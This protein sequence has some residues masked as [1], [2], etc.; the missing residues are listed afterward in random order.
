MITLAL[1][2]SVF[3][4]S[5]IHFLDINTKHSVYYNEGADI[6]V[7]TSLNDTIR[8]FIQDLDGVEAISGIVFGL[9]DSTI[10]MFQ[11]RFV[12]PKT[13]PLAAYFKETLYGI[14]S[15]LTD[16]MNAITDNQSIILYEENLHSNSN[17]EIG[18]FLQVIHS[19]D[20]AQNI[21][22]LKISGTFRYWPGFSISQTKRNNI[23][24]TYYKAI[25]SLGLFESLKNQINIKYIS[26]GYHISLESDVAPEI[27]VS[28][29]NSITHTTPYSPKLAYQNYLKSFGRRFIVSILN[30]D[31]LICITIAVVSITMFAFFTYI[32]RGKEIGVERALGMTRTQLGAT[33]IIEGGIIML[34]GII[35][36]VNIGLFYSTVVI[37]L[38]ATTTDLFIIEYPIEFLLKLICGLF[39]ATVTCILLPVY[40]ATKKDISHILKSE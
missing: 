18:G 8:D 25:G 35:I 13:F 4:S 15:P 37:R 26:T 23:E 16:L 1:T 14:S 20:S 5:F 6:S 30:S 38:F 31:L 27:I 21:I 34:F 3:S 2:Y 22:S 28:Q 10:P 40:L 39:L 9:I 17:L 32:E 33:F 11:F 7:S 24:H 29:I 36:G 12:D 19:N